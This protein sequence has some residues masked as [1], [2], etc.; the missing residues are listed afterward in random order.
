MEPIVPIDVNE[1]LGRLRTANRELIEKKA[2]H[3]A[4]IAELQ[5]QAASLV[6]RAETAEKRLNTA[7]VA[8]PFRDMAN[9]IAVVPELWQDQFSKHFKLVLNSADELEIRNLDDTLTLGKGGKPVPFEAPALVELLY[10]DQPEDSLLRKI[11]GNVLIGSK[12]SG[13]GATGANSALGRPFPKNEEKKKV[14]MPQF[15]LK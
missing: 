3:K 5:T 9:K 11:M 10:T 8:V 2:T 14:E 15:G 13:G 4:R 6:T 7:M 12:A 1:E